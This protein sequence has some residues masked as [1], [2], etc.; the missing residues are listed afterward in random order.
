MCGMEGERTH[1]ASEG[2]SRGFGFPSECGR[3]CQ[4]FSCMRALDGLL[5]LPTGLRV[6]ITVCLEPQ[7]FVNEETE[8]QRGSSTCQRSHRKQNWTWLHAALQ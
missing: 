7:E 4:N 1:R 5:F 6:V 3:V 8:V 2:L